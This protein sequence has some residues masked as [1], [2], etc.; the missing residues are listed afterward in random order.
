MRGGLAHLANRFF[1]GLVPGRLHSADE[2][3]VRS[4]LSPDELTLWSRSAPR[5]Q[6]HSVGVARSMQRWCDAT[7]ADESTE[8]LA[9]AAALLHDI[10]K[11]EAPLGLIGRVVATV[12]EAAAGDRMGPVVE[13]QDIVGV[14]ARYCDYP[15]RGARLLEAAG[16]DPLVVAWSMEHHDSEDAWTIPHQ[17]GRALR[18]A[19]DGRLTKYIR[20]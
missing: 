14:V 19:D 11:V 1:R 2:Q 10:G 3:W 15:V 16:A 7:E 4:V 6:V 8:T 5:D 17:L 18:Q 9:V 12:T 13:R 20:E